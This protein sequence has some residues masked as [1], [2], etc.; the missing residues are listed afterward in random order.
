MHSRVSA[1]LPEFPWDTIADAKAAAAAHPDGIVDL[2]VGTPVDSVA[3]VIRDA[4]AAARTCPGIRRPPVRPHCDR[5]SVM[6]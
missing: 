3:P 6:R 2:S 1:S 5:P 4:L